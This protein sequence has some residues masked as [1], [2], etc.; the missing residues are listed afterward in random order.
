M[1]AILYVILW[2]LILFLL[3]Y[4]CFENFERL[5]SDLIEVATKK[6][7]ALSAFVLKQL[8]RLHIECWC[9]KSFKIIGR[10]KDGKF[11]TLRKHFNVMKE[12][13]QTL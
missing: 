11:N 8:K 10:D 3:G 6:N 13:R 5:N 7:R 9:Q 12:T 4:K 2:F 1:W